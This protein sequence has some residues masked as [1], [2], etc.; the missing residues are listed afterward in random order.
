MKDVKLMV[1]AMDRPQRFIT[2]SKIVTPM[3]REDNATSV[4]AIKVTH[5]VDAS[6][7]T[8]IAEHVVDAND[9]KFVTKWVDCEEPTRTTTL[10][11]IDGSR[12]EHVLED[13]KT[14]LRRIHD[15]ATLS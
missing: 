4:R 10:F 13:P 1:F 7:I 3:M 5:I 2:F 6:I 12:V 15:G 8:D 11:M 9:F 14:L